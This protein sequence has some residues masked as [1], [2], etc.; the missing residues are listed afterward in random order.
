LQRIVL[1]LERTFD[2][3]ESK[4]ANSNVNGSMRSRH[5]QRQVHEIA[6][7]RRSRRF[8]RV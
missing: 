8:E 5:E 6:S 7:S 3:S 2:M 1:K 4:I